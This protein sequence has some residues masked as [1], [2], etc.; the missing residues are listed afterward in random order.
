MVKG[1]SELAV[2]AA[3]MPFKISANVCGSS[4]CM[5]TDPLMPRVTK[6]TCFPIAL[7]GRRA[8]RLGED[9]RQQEGGRVV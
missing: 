5:G 9:A 2:P 7:Q 1:H 3:A 4:C 8:L 6:I